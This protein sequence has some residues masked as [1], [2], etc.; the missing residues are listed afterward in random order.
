MKQLFTF[1][2]DFSDTQ[3]KLAFLV[4]MVL[5]GLAGWVEHTTLF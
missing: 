5:L 3:A 2:E 1:E 4:F